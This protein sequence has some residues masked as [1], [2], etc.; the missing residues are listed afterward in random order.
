MDW[1]AGRQ[2]LLELVLMLAPQLY[3][4][5]SAL[6]G[7]SGS[8]GLP[9][10]DRP[11][12][13][14]I[15]H[16]FPE[17]DRDAGSRAI[18]SFA[19][20]LRDAGME[21][22]FWAATTQ[23]S[24]AG[25]QLLQ[26]QG[27]IALSRQDTGALQGWL[28]QDNIFSASVLSRPL[29]AA[30]YLSVVRRQVPGPVIYYGHDIHHQRLAAMGKMS[31]VDISVRWELLLMRV[32]ERRIWRQADIVLYPSNAE[33]ASVNQHHAACGRSGNAQMFPLWTVDASSRSR[34]SRPGKRSGLLFVGSASH[35]PNIDGL[36]WFLHEVFPL[37]MQ[38]GTDAVLTIVGSGMEKY[39][40]PT[41]AVGRVHVLGRVDD[42]E[43]V[44]CYARARVVIA[45]L[46]FGGGVKGKV[47]EAIDMGV[48]C[49]LT[50]AAAQGLDGIEAVLPVFDDPIDYAQSL[51]HLLSDD[52][53]W[54]KASV[55]ALEF[56]TMRYDY[57]KHVRRLRELVATINPSRSA[58]C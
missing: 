58:M 37:L 36:D 10:P 3:G 24:E 14:L 34:P 22:V 44:R 46:R 2:R 52:Q 29:I 57:V 47:L 13:L 11:R 43:L 32:V 18:A 23:A 39:Q 27:M 33:A 26:Q 30:M 17:P 45:P 9:P 7:S 38:E 50:T 51:K 49:V 25:R 19:G 12:V 56:L 28:Q 4:K 42:D 48:P 41:A 55:D 8:P 15:D 16:D 1:Q 5:L 20:L 54:S 6:R 53:A 21:V 40:I 31:T 35:R